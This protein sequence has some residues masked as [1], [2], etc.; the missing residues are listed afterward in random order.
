L[1]LKNRAGIAGEI[2]SIRVHHQFQTEVFVAG[3]AAR[4][5]DPDWLSEIDAS[6]PRGGIE[7]VPQMDH[8]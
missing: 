6:D 4:L 5:F 3:K 1:W 7:K 8:H 2:K